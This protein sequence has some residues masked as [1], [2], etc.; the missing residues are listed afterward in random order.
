MLSP[1][2][3]TLSLAMGDVLPSPLNPTGSLQVKDSRRSII[4]TLGGW[5]S[6]NPPGGNIL[7]FRPS[8][9][10]CSAASMSPRLGVMYL[11]GEGAPPDEAR[12]RRLTSLWLR[13]FVFEV[14]STRPRVLVHRATQFSGMGCPILGGTRFLTRSPSLFRRPPLLHGL[15]APEKFE[16]ARLGLETRDADHG[17]QAC[18]G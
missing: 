2:P 16:R 10:F 12:A 17:F 4:H 5:P 8:L 7:L 13:F 9:A 15:W 3:T 14:S 18:G 1:W 11:T 6:F